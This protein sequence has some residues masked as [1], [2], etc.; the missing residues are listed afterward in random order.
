[1]EV[2]APFTS[3]E[4]VADIIETNLF[5]GLGEAGKGEATPGLRPGEGGK[6]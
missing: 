6:A 5:Q 4:D 3:G 2:V 1:M